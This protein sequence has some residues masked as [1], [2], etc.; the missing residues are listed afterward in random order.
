MSGNGGILSLGS[1]KIVF[2]IENQEVFVSSSVVANLERI[3]S[4]GADSKLRNRY[5]LAECSAAYQKNVPILKLVAV[6]T[7][8]RTFAEHF[9]KG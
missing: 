3:E 2:L 6:E 9:K 7:C 8:D 5:H 1:G 4:I